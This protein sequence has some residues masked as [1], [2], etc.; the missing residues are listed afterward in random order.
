MESRI[1]DILKEKG[2]TISSLAEQIGT[3]QTSLSR[4]LGEN[5]NPTFDTLSKIANALGVS[6]SELF[7]PAKEGVIHCPKCGTEIK[8]N[9]EI[10]SA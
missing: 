7:D 1:K 4:A 9:P 5:G 10:E 3:P 2:V 6:V 8:L